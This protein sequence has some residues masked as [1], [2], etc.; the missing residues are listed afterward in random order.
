[1]EDVLANLDEET[2][3]QI[4][5][6]QIFEHNFQQLLMQKQAFS[7]EL[8]EINMSLDELEKSEGEVFKIVGGI[9]I[10]STK[11]KLKEDLNHKKELIGLRLKS[12]DKQ[13]KEISKRAEELREEIMK[14][15]SA[16]E[17]KK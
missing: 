9:I 11:E 6:L 7:G 4:Q 12:I 5:E 13:E 16:N 1:M 3:K 17:N 2:Q 15:I 14:K 8:N 10:K